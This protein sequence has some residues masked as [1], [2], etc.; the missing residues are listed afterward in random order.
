VRDPAVAQATHTMNAANRPPISTSEP[1]H[2]VT[3]LFAIVCSPTGSAPHVAPFF[4]PKPMA[5]A[6]VVHR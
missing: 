1:T 6:Y 3:N 4:T 5:N 2:G